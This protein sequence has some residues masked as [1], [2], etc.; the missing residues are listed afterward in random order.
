MAN[1]AERNFSEHFETILE[2]GARHGVEEGLTLRLAQSLGSAGLIGNELIQRMIALGFQLHEND[3]RTFEPYNHHLARVTL[4]LLDR[5]MIR[6]PEVIAAAPVH[7]SIEDHPRELALLHFEDVPDDEHIQREMAHMALTIL[8][9]PNVAGYTL[10]VSNPLIASDED[11]IPTYRLHTE[12]LIRHGSPGGVVIKLADFFHN[13]ETPPEENPAKRLRL[14]KKQVHVYDIHAAGLERPD[15]L[16]P[17][18]VRS[19]TKR[20][21]TARRRRALGRLADS[22]YRLDESS[23]RSA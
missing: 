1:A 19:K 20:T 2:L 23:L 18:E 9:T 14:D 10:E 22:A 13:T 8:S 11:R 15:S 21:L 7:D 17:A 5:F 4:E 3:R 6:D 12:R 16:V